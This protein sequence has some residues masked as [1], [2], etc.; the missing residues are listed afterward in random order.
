MFGFDEDDVSI[1]PRTVEFIEKN[2]I[3]RP[4]FF[5]LTPVPKTRLYQRLLLEGRIIETDW[6]HADGTRVM[7]RPKL[8]T[9]DE[10]QEGYRWVTDQ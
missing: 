1:F 10:L 8:M 6:S 7:F 4:L 9:A 2:S 3:D 5:I